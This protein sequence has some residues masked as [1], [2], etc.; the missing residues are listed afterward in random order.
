MH[1]SIKPALALVSLTAA[2]VAQNATSSSEI[3]EYTIAAEGITAK[4]IPYGARLTS[5][6]VEDRNGTEQDIALGY[7]NPDDYVKDTNTNHTYFGELVC[8]Q[9]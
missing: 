3:P 6:L 8:F 1:F 7:D 4:L 2:V 5:L 9:R